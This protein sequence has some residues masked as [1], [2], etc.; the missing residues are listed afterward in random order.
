[1]F[2]RKVS[3][4]LKPGAAAGFKQAIEGQVIPLLRKQK[5]FL[6]EI[7]LLYPSG[8]EVHAFSLWET[9]E[10]AAAYNLGTYAEAAKILGSVVEGAPRLQTYEVL[11]STFHNIGAAVAA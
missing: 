7:T 8:K 1:M 11:N 4:R 2:A 10:N 3:M 9:A 5:G 6:G